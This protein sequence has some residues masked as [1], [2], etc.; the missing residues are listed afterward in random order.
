[1]L[2]SSTKST[3]AVAALLH[4][5]G[6]VSKEKPMRLVLEP[7]VVFDAAGVVVA[8]DALSAPASFRTTP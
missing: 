7:R 4:E 3:A 6:A 8:A 5:L 2:I 1:M